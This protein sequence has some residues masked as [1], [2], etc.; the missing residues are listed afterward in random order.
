MPKE[1]K[2][3]DNFYA[4][5]AEQALQ[6]VSDYASRWGENFEEQ[7][8][9]RLEASM[10]DEQVK[11]IITRDG[12]TDTF[13]IEEAISLRDLWRALQTVN[14]IIEQQGCEHFDS[15]VKDGKLTTLIDVVVGG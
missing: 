15:A 9:E 3:N 2:D 12:T 14:M 8:P 7:F 5:D 11:A 4:L 10:T 6:I 1:I 13:D